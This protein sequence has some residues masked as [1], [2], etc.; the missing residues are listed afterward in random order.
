[1]T[2]KDGGQMEPTEEALEIVALIRA[3]KPIPC[4]KGSADRYL[5][6]L[7]DELAALKDALAVAVAERKL[8]VA[9]GAMKRVRGPR[10]KDCACDDA[11]CRACRAAFDIAIAAVQDPRLMERVKA[12]S[13]IVEQV[14]KRKFAEA[15]LLQEDFDRAKLRE[16]EGK[17]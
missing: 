6:A 1:M 14:R 15:V 12:E 16:L 17:P 11:C 7:A 10:A 8:A 2:P 13:A 4:S 9:F 3:G 5:L